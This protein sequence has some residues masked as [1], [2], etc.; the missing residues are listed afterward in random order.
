[1]RP[2]SIFYL[3]ISSHA[4]EGRAGQRIR[5]EGILLN[6]SR[7]PFCLGR[8][9]RHIAPG[10]AGKSIRLSLDGEN[11]KPRVLAGIDV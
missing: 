11:L 9:Q 5:G 1:M 2:H 8:F 10:T 3:G 7:S 6:C 4:A